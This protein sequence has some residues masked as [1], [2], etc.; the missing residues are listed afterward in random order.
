M[1][2]AKKTP[3]AKSAEPKAPRKPRVPKPVTDLATA[4]AA[5]Q[6]AKRSAERA[7][8][9]ADEARK[10][11][12]DANAALREAAQV[13]KGYMGEVDAAVG[14]VLPEP[15]EDAPVNDLDGLE[16]DGYGDNEAETDAPYNDEPYSG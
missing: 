8:K 9:A 12:A 13:L 7:S 16:H 6:K 4:N 11:E 5:F 1:V 15:A 14:N 2:A 3:A 10:T